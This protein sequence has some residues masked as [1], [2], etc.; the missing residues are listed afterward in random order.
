MMDMR[1]LAAMLQGMNPGDLQGLSDSLSGLQ[2]QG[3]RIGTPPMGAN[4][5]SARPAMQ[6][7][8]PMQTQGSQQE[9]SNWL[10]GNGAP[11]IPVVHSREGASANTLSD[12]QRMRFDNIRSQF[13]G[14]RAAAARDNM[15]MHNQRRPQIP[16]AQAPQA[17]GPAQVPTVTLPAVQPMQPQGSPDMALQQAMRR[18]R[19][20]D[21]RPE[22]P[23]ARRR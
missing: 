19:A 18:A 16:V 11:K 17:M 8:R 7:M 1:Q 9:M 13:G 4:Q 6:P 21:A 2:G 22:I 23:R 10:Q 3:F 15:L 20:I 12:G 14:E 5:P